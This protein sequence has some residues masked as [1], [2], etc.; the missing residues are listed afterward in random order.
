MA[1][2]HEIP[3]HLNVEDKAFFGLSVRQTMN[4]TGG[5]AGTYGLWNQWPDMPLALRA[6]LAILSLLLALAF[7]LVRVYGRGLDEW[8][9]VLLHYITTPKTSV[10]QP[11]CSVSDDRRPADA[12]WEELH[13]AV[14]WEAGR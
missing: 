6:T 7:T 8:L 13:P 11:H 2:R 3:T 14:S 4:L 9:F 5:A 10:W 1:K 12:P